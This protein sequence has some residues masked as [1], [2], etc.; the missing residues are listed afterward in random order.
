MARRPTDQRKNARN[1]F[2]N[3]SA[4]S[5]VVGRQANARQRSA[6]GIRGSGAGREAAYQYSTIHLQGTFAAD[7][8]ISNQTASE[9]GIAL[10]EATL[11]GVDLWIW[12]GDM[13][14]RDGAGRLLAMTDFIADGR[15]WWDAMCARD[16]RTEGHG[17]FPRDVGGPPEDG[18]EDV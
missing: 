15:R 18:A 9:L 12:F 3:E 16:P 11:L 8:R 1:P 2:A 14:I 10:N 4:A 17:I 13:T 5:R 6:V 7:V